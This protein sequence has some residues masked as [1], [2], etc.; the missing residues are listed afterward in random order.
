MT[1]A[2]LTTTAVC[3][4]IEGDAISDSGKRSYVLI[5]IIEPLS[6]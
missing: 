2:T 1:V 6:L 3:Q 4:K 5:D